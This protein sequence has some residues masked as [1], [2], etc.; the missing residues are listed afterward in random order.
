MS[1]LEQ[2]IEWREQ[3]LTDKQFTLILS[4]FVGFFAAIAAFVLHWIISQ[5]QYILLQALILIISTGF[6]LYIRLSVFSLH[7]YL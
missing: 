5:I 1:L 6:I 2:M 3:H 7:L 4:F